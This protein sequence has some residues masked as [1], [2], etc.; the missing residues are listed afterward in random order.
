MLFLAGDVAMHQFRMFVVLGFVCVALLTVQTQASVLFVDDDA[1]PGGDGASWNT[2]FRFLQDALAAAQQPG[3]AVTEI[4]VGQGVYIPTFSATS[5]TGSDDRDA[6]FSMVDGVALT[7]GFAGV[8]AA[9][10][11]AYSPE[12]FETV[13]ESELGPVGNCCE[14]HSTGGCTTLYCRNE[15]CAIRP[16]CCTGAWDENCVLFAEFL[17]GFDCYTMDW[18]VDQTVNVMGHT[19]PLVISGFTI[20]VG[21]SRH[22]DIGGGVIVMGSEVDISNCKF[23]GNVG[24]WRDAVHLESGSVSI[25]N[26]S[27]DSCFRIMRANNAVIA[28]HNATSTNCSFGI[29]CVKSVVTVIGSTFDTRLPAIESE[30]SDVTV[31]RCTFTRPDDGFTNFWGNGMS[32]EGGVI[33]V[34]DSLFLGLG[35]ERGGAVNLEECPSAQFTNC[36]FQGNRARSYAGAMQTRGT[37][38]ELRQC[39]FDSNSVVVED[40][41]TGN[42]GALLVRHV[43]NAM[44]VECEFL[45]NR[46]EQTVGAAS[47][48]ADALVMEDCLFINNSTEPTNFGTTGA[49]SV[50]TFDTVRR[51]VF[52]GNRA[53]SGGAIANSAASF[54]GCVFI[55]N[56]SVGGPGG[57]IR[58]SFFTIVSLTNC[59]LNNNHAIGLDGNTEYSFGGAIATDRRNAPRMTNCSFVSNS[60]G[61][62][63]GAVAG[64]TV[65]QNASGNTGFSLH[66]CIVWNNTDSTGAGEDAQ[67]F[68]EPEQADDVLIG[69]CNIEGW[70]GALG[71]FGNFG[72]DPMFIDIDGPDDIPGNADDDL[73]LMANSP[74]IDAGNNNAL[75]IDMFD[76]DGDGNTS[77][78]YPVDLDGNP[79][80]ADVDSAVDVG[81]GM[82][83]VVDMGAYEV[84]GLAP[85]KLLPGDID[86]DG[87]PDA[88]DLMTLL[89]DWADV[90]TDQCCPADINADGVVDVF[91]L[92]RLLELWAAQAGG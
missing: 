47:I 43:D 62:R 57:A 52:V 35:A 89:K 66:N 78:L 31:D 61:A 68:I 17:C 5:P 63:G 4:R 41:N 25:W 56:T 91:D 24:N 2:A 67:V 51:C 37:P 34:T 80:V 28:L 19:S 7:G 42:V 40:N 81:C 83:A 30:K 92:L 75:P 33:D 46:A 84:A 87:Q 16:L 73:R 45:N 10:P 90:C 6:T 59:V 26:T 20:S 38:I 77:E 70:S 12:M 48:S 50:D 15:V 29:Q 86:G 49:L 79:R 55:D 22:G 69:N 21:D 11:D 53:W 9:D 13:L 3:S 64:Y 60:A 72:A 58:L 23:I 39:T 14:E 76:V 36:I 88:D 85:N 18:R 54:D 27:F 74:S 1:L 82:P 71:G 8:G 32:C 65:N 44:V